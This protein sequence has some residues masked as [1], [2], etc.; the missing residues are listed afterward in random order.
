[1]L[2]YSQAGNGPPRWVCRCDHKMLKYSSSSEMSY[3]SKNPGEH[4][5]VKPGKSSSWQGCASWT[6]RPFS[7]FFLLCRLTD[8]TFPFSFT[9]SS[10]G[11]RELIFS[12]QLGLALLGGSWTVLEKRVADVGPFLVTLL[13]RETQISWPKRSGH[14][15][16]FLSFLCISSKGLDKGPE[17]D[18][19]CFALLFNSV[20][21]GRVWLWLLEA[22]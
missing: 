5:V 15:V 16:F 21:V 19:S 20:S 4:S 2:V 18:V 9:D 22:G 3:S 6:L 1:M 11:Q 17:N 7:G 13:S 8:A 12:S 14:A 10:V